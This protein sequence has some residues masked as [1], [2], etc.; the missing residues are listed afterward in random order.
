MTPGVRR[1]DWHLPDPKALPLEQ[2][3]PIRD[4]LARLV[5]DLVDELDRARTGAVPMAG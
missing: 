1:V 3:R 4:E 5:D 2:V